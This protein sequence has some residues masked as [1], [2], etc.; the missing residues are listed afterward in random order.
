M[1]NKY[2]QIVFSTAAAI[3]AVLIILWLVGGIS[4]GIS[5]PALAAPLSPVVTL[6]TP[7]MPPTIWIPPLLSPGQVSR[8][9][10]LLPW[11]VRCLRT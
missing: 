7:P 2:I 8:R 1:R 9:C 4:S 6:W 3:G 11:A 5:T 10:P